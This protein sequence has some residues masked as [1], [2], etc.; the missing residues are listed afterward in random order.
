M[1]SLQLVEILNDYFSRMNAI[2]DHHCGHIN[3]FIGDGLM[4]V[5]GAPVSR[6]D[7]GEAWA[8]VACGLEMLQEVALMNEEAEALGRP[9]I[10]I[11]V[12]IHTGEAVCGVI[13]SARRMEYTIIGDTVNLAARLESTTKEFGV[14]LLISEAT[15]V[16]VNRRYKTRPLGEVTVK[17]KTASTTLFTVVERRNAPRFRFAGGIRKT[18]GHKL[19]KFFPAPETDSQPKT[20]SQ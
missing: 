10:Q 19:P 5:F 16:L 17:G 18:A 9:R 15:A 7:T 8:A 6:G 11:G 1:P 2:V 3:K 13:G 4:I 12:G 20:D 14:P